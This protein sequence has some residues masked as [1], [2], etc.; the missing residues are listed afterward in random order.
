MFGSL[1]SL[2][3]YGLPMRLCWLA[4]LATCLR[5]PTSAPVPHHALRCPK[6]HPVQTPTHSPYP[7]ALPEGVRPR[8]RQAC[9][10]PSKGGDLQACPLLFGHIGVRARFAPPPPYLSPTG[11][12]P[13]PPAIRVIGSCLHCHS[14]TIAFW[15]LSFR[16]A[17]RFICLVAPACACVSG[18]S[19]PPAL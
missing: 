7:L 15:F 10:T 8:R 5:T 11:S 3:A 6:G 1:R 16:A 19:V 18:S 14:S 13:P 2:P 17:A 4:S 12:D 9:R